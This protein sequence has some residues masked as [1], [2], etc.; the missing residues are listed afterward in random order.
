MSFESWLIYLFAVTGL[1]FA[2][3]PNVLLALSHGAIY[4]RRK[5]LATISGGV[6]G[7]MI[8]IAL[9]MIGIGSLM[10]ASAHILTV[11]KWLGGA[12]LIYLGIQLWRSPG[13]AIGKLDSSHQLSNAARFRQGF[14]SAI[15]NPKVLL[16]FGAFLPQF[17]NQGQP[18]LMQFLI[19]ASTYAVMEFLVEFM[20]ASAATRLRPWLEKSGRRFNQGCGSLFALLGASLPLTQ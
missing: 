14:L 19:M 15:A 2:P 5:T 20:V 12:Y 4:G 1:A 7:F 13:I 11:C 16:F 18:L 3:G 6:S 8:V 10:Q 9:S 17:I